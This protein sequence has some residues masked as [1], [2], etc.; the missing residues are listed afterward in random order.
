MKSRLQQ[1]ALVLIVLAGYTISSPAAATT[2]RWIDISGGSWSDATNW[3]HQ[4]APPVGGAPDAILTFP[5]SSSYLFN[6]TNDLGG[7]FSLNQLQFGNNAADLFTVTSSSGSS[8]SFTGTNPQI[9][10]T[11][12]GQNTLSGGVALDADLSVT[13][14]LGS[15]EITS[16]I[17]GAHGI[18]VNGLET[19]A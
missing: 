5:D 2:Y 8:L 15:L 4:L 12:I 16:F 9:N 14:S 6:A 10:V 7:V 3:F 1:L 17:S 11:G 18:T 13:M 19:A